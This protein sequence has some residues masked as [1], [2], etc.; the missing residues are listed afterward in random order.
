[1]TYRYYIGMLGFLN[2]DFV[3][4]YPLLCKYFDE[5]YTNRLSTIVRTGADDGILHLSHQR[6]A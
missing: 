1:M 6:K 2:E 5:N 3:K 4:V